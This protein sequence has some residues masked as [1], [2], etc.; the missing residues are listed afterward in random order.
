[1]LLRSLFTPELKTGL[2]FI[3]LF[4]AVFLAAYLGGLGPGILATLL[5]VVTALHFFIEP[6]GGS[7]SL[8]NPVASYGVL[9]FT[10]SGAA[11]AWLGETRLRGHRV[12]KE[13]A[14]TAKREAAR[15]E[16][17]AI[18]AEEEAARA[19]EESA[20]AE[21]EMLRAEEE[22]A[23]AEQEA[24][25]AARASERVERILASI[26]DAFTVWTTTG[27]SPT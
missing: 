25:R 9:L 5:G 22:S 14:A 11:T 23:R 4:P 15:A 13:M 2:P 20:R 3:T 12:A 7:L 24:H 1:V 18:R 19:E 17:E 6:V 21:E 8:A 16:Q 27:P 10:L 26:T